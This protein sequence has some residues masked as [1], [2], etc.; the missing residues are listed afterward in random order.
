MP[1]STAM[2]GMPA[3]LACITAGTT[4]A[5]SVALMISTSTPRTIRSSMSETCVLTLSCAS[6]TS[7]STPASSAAACAPSRRVTKNGLLRVDN[8]KPTVPCAK[9]A[10]ARRAARVTISLRMGAPLPGAGSAPASV[11]LSGPPGGQDA[12]DEQRGQDHPSLHDLLVEARNVQQVH[13][14]VD[15]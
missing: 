9:T 3:A 1:R 12:V 2:T 15:D 8:D 7:R 10:L 6:V 11:G 14:V 5:E 13:A 4:A